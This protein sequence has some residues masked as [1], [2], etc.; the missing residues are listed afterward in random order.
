MGISDTQPELLQLQLLAVEDSRWKEGASQTKP[1]GS[2][3]PGTS[4]PL[5]CTREDG[6]FLP[7]GVKA[8]EL[9]ILCH[10]P[11]YR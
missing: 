11:L 6:K 3:L 7:L 2:P 8:G 4:R 1:A 9:S 10:F 5:L